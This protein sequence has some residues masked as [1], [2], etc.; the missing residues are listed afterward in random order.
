MV[1]SATISPWFPWPL[2]TVATATFRR[3]LA[4]DG[5]SSLATVFFAIH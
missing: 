3:P 4:S 1:P 2:S 5:P